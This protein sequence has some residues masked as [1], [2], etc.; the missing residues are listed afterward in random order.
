[1]EKKNK[2]KIVSITLSPQNLEELDKSI[3]QINLFGLN[4]S[5]ILEKLLTDFLNEIQTKNREEIIHKLI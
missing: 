3:L 5:R 4:R 1:M 2:K